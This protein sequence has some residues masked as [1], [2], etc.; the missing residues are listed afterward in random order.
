MPSV[1]RPV[2]RSSFCQAECSVLYRINLQTISPGN[3]RGLV[4]LHL[5]LDVLIGDFR[6][7]YHR[8]RGID[9]YVMAR[10][11]RLSYA[12]PDPNPDRDHAAAIN[13]LRWDG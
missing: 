8:L 4:G 11:L 1:R 3:L 12:V 13:C 6:S 7:G 2:S 5:A 9:P 10:G